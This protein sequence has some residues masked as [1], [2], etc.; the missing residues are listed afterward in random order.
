MACTDS[1]HTTCRRTSN[2]MSK[3]SAS[4]KFT[5]V[6][7]RY[8]SYRETRTLLCIRH[9]TPPCARFQSLDAAARV[10]R[11]AALCTF[12]ASCTFQYADPL[13]RPNQ[14][15]HGTTTNT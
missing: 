13:Q 10:P 15:K 3:A 1:Q 5:L 14:L 11:N 8:S 4:S 12:Y 7:D 2:I 9:D 6:H